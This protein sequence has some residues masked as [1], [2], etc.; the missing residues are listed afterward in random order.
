MTLYY[1]INFVLN[2][3]FFGARLLLH[4]GFASTSK[5]KLSVCEPIRVCLAAGYQAAKRHQV[6][7]RPYREGSPV[8]I[9]NTEVKPRRADGT[10]RVNC[11][12][13]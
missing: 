8:P 9:P 6:C 4:L 2:L 13:D 7:R 1:P 12:G 10:A 5:K 11:V 3:K